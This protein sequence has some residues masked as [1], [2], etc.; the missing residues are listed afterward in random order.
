MLARHDSALAT[1]LA[2]FRAAEDARI[3]ALTLPDPA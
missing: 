2:A 3:R 1:N